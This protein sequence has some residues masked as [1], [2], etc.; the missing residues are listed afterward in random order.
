MSRPQAGG[1][2][3]SSDYNLEITE[4][5]YRNFFLPFEAGEFCR[6]L[7]RVDFQSF[8]RAVRSLSQPKTKS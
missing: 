1:F 3:K 8:A 7:S 2:T 5:L 4:V 6:P